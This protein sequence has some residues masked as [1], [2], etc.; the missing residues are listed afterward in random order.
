MMKRAPTRSRG[1]DPGPF[2]A[3]FVR[4]CRFAVTLSR[5]QVAGSTFA[6]SSLSVGF[7]RTASATG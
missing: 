6:G 5:E 1:L 7:D 4:A 3:G 2:T